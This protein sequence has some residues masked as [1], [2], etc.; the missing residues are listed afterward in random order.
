MKRVSAR[1]RICLGQ[2]LLLLGVLM[3]AVMLNFVPD[4]RKHV[5]AGRAVLCE[6][7]AVNASAFVSQDDAR[8]MEA[9][10]KVLVD[11]NPEILS[12]G[13][14]S[15]EG[16]LVVD[17][18]GHAAAWQ[19]LADEKSTDAQV[20]VP[21]WSGRNRWG[22]VE[23]RFQPLQQSGILAWL[24][25]PWVC[26][27]AFMVAVMYL[28][29]YVYLGR[30]LEQLNPSKAVP[31]R[32]RTALDTLSEGLL[33]LDNEERIVLANQAFA[34]TVGVAAD[35]LVGKRV[36]QFAW[37]HPTASEVE[38]YPW[39]AA[40]R[41]RQPQ[42]GVTL[43]MDVD[44]QTRR[45]FIV[46]CVPVLGP[47][48]EHRGVMVT[49]E[50][51]T[52]LEENR[53][54]LSKSKDAAES[55]NRAKS[56]F[57]ANMSHEIRTPMNAI[58]GFSDI[59]R[60]GYER[61]ESERREYLDTI[62]S[63]GEHLLELIN[64]ILDLSKVESGRLK[65]ELQHC[66]I[67]QVIKDVTSVLGKRAHEKGL[68]IV[69]EPQELPET[70]LTDPGRVRQILTNLLGNA[71]KFT[72]EGEVGIAVS[73]QPEGEK[74]QLAIDVSDTGIGMTSEQAD[75]IFDPFMQADASI[76]RR[77]GGTGL[78]LSISRRLARALGG[79]ILVDSAPG[80]GS[81]FRVLIDTGPL[82]GVAIF[83]PQD[84]PE[85]A[86]AVADRPQLVLP[87]ARLLL[88][89]DGEANRRLLSV[90]M[91]RAGL[92]VDCAENGQVAVQMATATDYDAILMDMQMP[93]MDG[94]TAATTLRNQGQTLP[95][96]ALTADAMLGAEEKCRAAGCSGFFT[97]PVNIDQLLGYL[98]ELLRGHPSESLVA[99]AAADET[100]NQHLATLVAAEAPAGRA[101]NGPLEQTAGSPSP[102][103]SSLPA[104]D[105]VFREIVAGF[106]DTL[107]NKLEALQQAA[108]K[109]EFEEV[110]RIAH[111]LKGAAGT[112]GFHDFTEP[113]IHLQACAREQ[114]A[115]EVDAAIVAIVELFGR[116]AVEPSAATESTQTGTS[117]ADAVPGCAGSTV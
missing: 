115:E 69:Y 108:D 73:L 33:V 68:R 45:I 83:C 46:N 8:R 104:T 88:V 86:S 85:E 7:V 30:M 114:V 82:D 4:Y 91:E 92:V 6:S 39:T 111:W 2:S 23:V 20:Q 42:H 51:V 47:N 49:L 58:M 80:Q 75:T 102:V 38:V 101:T 15:S 21:I 24:T 48:R 103:V 106:V 70:I 36:S 62:H 11:R 3:C 95:I 89:D 13:I 110:A 64:D 63:S 25:R 107:S 19:P 27:T 117:P 56:D 43:Q 72:A 90:V 16:A 96:I 50:D 37:C 28:V 32:V 60:R 79:D 44:D 97:K 94:F 26:H 99:A 116:I 54:E 77:F 74:P 52:R 18:A 105:P 98:A 71:I 87:P 31:E 81:T 14:R 109:R 100:A 57:L 9:I 12:A 78:G 93:V 10:L 40:I 1:T 17:I 34:S 22:D 35:S 76:T 53:I 61:D 5:M 67:H 55:A 66:S 112:V 84:A 41:D 65:V 59:L 113:A 29:F